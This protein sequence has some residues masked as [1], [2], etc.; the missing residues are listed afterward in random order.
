MFNLRRRKETQLLR[1]RSGLWWMLAL[2]L[3]FQSLLLNLLTQGESEAVNALLVWGGAILAFAEQSPKESA[4]PGRLQTL[5]GITIVVA[6]LWRSQ[7]LVSP[8]AVAS[9]LP[10]LAGFGL[11]LLAAPARC[12][13]DYFRPLVI[14][15]LLP[16]T[17]AASLIPT[18][19][20]SLITA[21]VTQ[22][23][24]LLSGLP[25]Q[26]SGN[27]VQLPGGAVEI[28]GPCSGTNMLI[29]LLVVGLIFA[30]LFPMQRR[31]QGSIMLVVAAMLSILANGGRIALLALIT[32]SRIP[33]K[34]WLFDFFHDGS[35]SLIF[36]G[37]AVYAFV[38]LYGLWMEW[39]VS[40]L[41]NCR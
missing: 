37:I 8:D 36:S 2:M 23:L 35:G 1:S 9:L 5:T 7:R 39:Q 27:T 17:I 32:T 25:A 12:I 18:R 40:Q 3:T 24:L 21:R 38:W 26:A 15:G 28:A 4:I 41:R 29:Q 30:L 14:L 10:L 33:S 22:F 20:L 34:D 6:V 31:W 19:E 13:K 16:I 11:V